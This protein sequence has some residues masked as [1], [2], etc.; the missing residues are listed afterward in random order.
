MKKSILFLALSSASFAAT[1]YVLPGNSETGFWDLNNTNYNPGN[2]PAYPVT[3]ATS[4]PWGG[5]ITAS[6]TSATFTRVSG[7]GYF[8]GSGSGIYGSFSPVTYAISDAAPITD[9]AT[10]VFQA[11]MNLA[12]TSVT[13]SLNGAGTPIL[14]NFFYTAPAG[15]GS[16]GPISDFGWQWDLSG[17]A[18]PITSYDIT[19]EMPGNSLIYGNEAELTTIIA[20]DTFA[21]VIPE[22]SVSLLGLAAITLNLLRHRRA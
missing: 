18:E 14:A 15:S 3:G 16:F 8:I 10:L 13:L 6:S 20:G 1:S 7:G 17:I 22:P 2:T 5:P 4:T 9:L 12:P 11:R 21:Q 19:V